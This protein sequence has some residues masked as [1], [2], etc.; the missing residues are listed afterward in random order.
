MIEHI[1]TAEISP[2]CILH[3]SN[4]VYFKS[5]CLEH[6]VGGGL[7]SYPKGMWKDANSISVFCT[8]EVDI[9]Q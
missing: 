3:F 1:M 4:F 9:R 7:C 2:A 8:L 5:K 6:A